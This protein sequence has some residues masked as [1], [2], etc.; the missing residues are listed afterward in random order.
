M[1]NNLGFLIGRFQPFHKGHYMRKEIEQICSD[2]ILTKDINKTFDKK[3]SYAIW[4]GREISL[5]VKLSPSSF[6]K[7]R[8]AKVSYYSH[9]LNITPE[10][11]FNFI[12]E[13]DLIRIRDTLKDIRKN[14]KAESEQNVNKNQSISSSQYRSGSGRTSGYSSSSNSSSRDYDDSFSSY[15]S[16]SSSSSSS[17]S[18]SSSSSSSSSCD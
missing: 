15:S 9:V 2:I 3:D 1:K 10:G 11:L 4:F 5:T 7:Q 6:Y 17:C 16:S 13:E 12:N 8:T 18:G 14:L